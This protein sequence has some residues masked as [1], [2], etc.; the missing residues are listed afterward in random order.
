MKTKNIIIS[1]LIL[2]LC[3]SAAAGAG[4][5]N[6]EISTRDNALKG[7]IFTSDNAGMTVSY[8]GKGDKI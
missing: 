1:L 3:A 8:T 5:Y 6:Q 4:T 2:I 7:K